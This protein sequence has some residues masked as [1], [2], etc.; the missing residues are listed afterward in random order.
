MSGPAP[1]SKFT[2]TKRPGLAAL[3]PAASAIRHPSSVIC[4][5]ISSPFQHSAFSLQHFPFAMPPSFRN[6]APLG[7]R[8]CPPPPLGCAP[9][10][11]QPAGSCPEPCVGE[12]SGGLKGVPPTGHGKNH[13]E[14]PCGT[15]SKADTY[16]DMPPE[17]KRFP[18]PRAALKCNL[19]VFKTIFVYA[20][21]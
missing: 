8:N 17:T 4:F 18:L 14:T 11:P 1:P 12:P 20:L 9:R 13:Q 21:A 5:P 2:V 7:S 16:S 10:A 15:A 19:S 6:S 3:Q